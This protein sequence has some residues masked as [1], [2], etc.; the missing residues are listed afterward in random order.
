MLFVPYVKRV[1]NFLTQDGNR[2]NIATVTR[3]KRVNPEER[4]GSILMSI[5]ERKTKKTRIMLFLLAAIMVISYSMAGIGEAAYAAAISNAPHAVKVGDDKLAVVGSKAEAEKVID[6]IVEEYTDGLDKVESVNVEPQITA[7]PAM[8]AGN[9]VAAADK[10]T[11]S[12]ISDNEKEGNFEVVATG[13]QYLRKNTGHKTVVKKNSKL[14]KGTKKVTQKGVDGVIDYTKERVYVNGELESSKIVERDV[15]TYNKT[16][17]IHEGTLSGSAVVAEAKKY[18]GNP[19]VYGGNSLTKGIDCSAFTQQIYA[20][21]GKTLPRTSSAQRSVR[22]SVPYSQAKPGDL[23]CYSGHVAIYAGNGK[24]V[25]AARP[26]KG[27]C[28]SSATYT[29]I[30]TV[31]RVI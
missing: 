15:V 9:Q 29:K 8:F 25:H 14:A 13:E 19:Y 18:L 1:L 17:V 31:R 27:I 24:I 30:L 28:I 11:E 10:A 7:E 22:K 6:G 23:I 12:I 20:K 4:K 3:R 5:L 21:F 2:V 16:E 26:G